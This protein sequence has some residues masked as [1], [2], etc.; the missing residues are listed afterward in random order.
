MQII[1]AL[2]PHRRGIYAGAVGYVGFGG[3]MDTCI[4]LRTIVMRGGVAELQAGAG[5]VADSVPEAEHQE[6][7]NK[8]GALQEAVDVAEQGRYGR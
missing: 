5:I 4:A 8:L 1:S 2:E 3:E 7:L 6:C